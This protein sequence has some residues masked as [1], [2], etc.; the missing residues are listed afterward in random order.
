MVEAVNISKERICHIGSRFRHEK[1]DC[2]L[3]TAFVHSESKRCSKNI[4]KALLAAEGNRCINMMMSPTAPNAKEKG[5]E[6][7]KVVPSAGKVMA[8]VLIDYFEKGKIIIGASYTLLDKL[9]SKIS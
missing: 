9:K 6:V 5:E 4:C 8:I 1:A 2:A 3:G 7:V